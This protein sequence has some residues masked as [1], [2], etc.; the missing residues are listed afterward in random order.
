VTEKT[1]LTGHEVIIEKEGKK[2]IKNTVQKNGYGYKLYKDGILLG[3][4]IYRNTLS[5][6]YMKKEDRMR[7]HYCIG[8]T[9]T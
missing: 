1:E 3:T 2:Y 4:N 8:K 6:V 5:P 7:H 9:G